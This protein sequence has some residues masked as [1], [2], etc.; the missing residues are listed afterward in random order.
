MLAV[1]EAVEGVLGVAFA[2]AEQHVATQNALVGGTRAK[3]GIW[4]SPSRK[5]LLARRTLVRALAGVC[6]EGQKNTAGYWRTH[7]DLRDRSWRFTCSS[8][9]N[10]RSHKLHCLRAMVSS[11]VRSELSEKSQP[12]G[13]AG[14]A[15]DLNAG[16]LRP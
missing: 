12:S 3:Y 16:K 11:S 14:S 2:V 15:G 8:L 10:L 1:A 9:V 7:W 4:A 6:G 13:V 5:V